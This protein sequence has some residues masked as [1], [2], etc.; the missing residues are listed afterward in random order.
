M[1]AD[2]AENPNMLLPDEMNL[3]I[4]MMK[5]ENISTEAMRNFLNDIMLIQAKSFCSYS[6]KD[7]EQVEV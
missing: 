6:E 4:E 2:S 3:L 7:D 1:T 5:A